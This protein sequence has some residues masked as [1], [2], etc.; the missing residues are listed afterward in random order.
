MPHFVKKQTEAYWHY[1]QLPFFHYISQSE[2]QWDHKNAFSISVKT[3]RAQLQQYL[4]LSH[5]FR[6]TLY[7]RMLRGKISNNI[8]HLKE[9]VPAWWTR[10]NFSAFQNKHA[11]WSHWLLCVN[12]PISLEE[13]LAKIIFVCQLAPILKI[14]LKLIKQ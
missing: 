11:A 12:Y 2:S 10:L 6:D 7:W 4:H 14:L 9:R 1:L 3:S 13:Q 5:G 8:R